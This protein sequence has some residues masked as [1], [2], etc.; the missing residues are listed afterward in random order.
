MG[1]HGLHRQRLEDMMKYYTSNEILEFLKVFIDRISPNS[2]LIP[3]A[4][5]N[6]IE[7]ITPLVARVDFQQENSDI[8][9]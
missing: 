4:K 8:C 5:G 9:E 6:E 7:V 2:V 3:Y 1:F